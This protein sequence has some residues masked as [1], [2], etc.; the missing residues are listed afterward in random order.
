VDALVQAQGTR[1]PI[2]LCTALEITH[3]GPVS[4]VDALVATQGASVSERSTTP[5][6]IAYKR[7]LSGVDA[8]MRAQG[9]PL[10]EQSTTPACVWLLSHMSVFVRTQGVRVLVRL[11]TA[12]EIAHERPLPRVDALVISQM[13]RS[14]IGL[15]ASLKVAHKLSALLA[16]SG[17]QTMCKAAPLAIQP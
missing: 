8:F 15:C 11:S 10:R 12:L 3:Q 2:S 7:L 5:I 6:E 4:C 1:M 16:L 13:A 17:G 9:S 14:S